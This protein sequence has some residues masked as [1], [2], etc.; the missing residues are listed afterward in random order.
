MA[1]S[2]EKEETVLLLTMKDG[3]RKKVTIPS[4]WKVTFGPLVPG[5]KDGNNGYAGIALRI[6][7]GKDQ[8]KA[9]FTQVES[10]RDLSIPL[11]EEH[12]EV[13]QERYVREGE[14]SG[15]AMNVEVRVKQWVNPDD[16]DNKPP[17][18]T[19]PSNIKSLIAQAKNPS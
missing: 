14:N 8:Q 11:M 10:F 18:E 17:Q 5:S 2:L 3:T 1:R 7:A 6:Y 15:E 13:K 9:V 16:R 4:S 12:E 19:K